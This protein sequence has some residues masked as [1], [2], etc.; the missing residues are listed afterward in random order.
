MYFQHYK[1]RA[2]VFAEEFIKNFHRIQWSDSN[3]VFRE[4]CFVLI[5]AG[6]LT[7][8]FYLVFMLMHVITG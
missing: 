7:L 3:R 1:R 8:F 2:I 4:T 6:I 5:I